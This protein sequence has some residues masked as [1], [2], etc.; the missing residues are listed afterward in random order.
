MNPS[1]HSNPGFAQAFKDLHF[2]ENPR[3][4]NIDIGFSADL[5]SLEFVPVAATWS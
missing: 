4:W 5:D 1:I 3:V 2:G